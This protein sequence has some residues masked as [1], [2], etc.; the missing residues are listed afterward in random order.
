MEDSKKDFISLILCFEDE[1]DVAI[2]HEEHRQLGGSDWRES[3]YRK[4]LQYTQVTK[5]C[6]VQ[7]QL[8]YM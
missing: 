1:T 2:D 6:V 4:R 7:R 5:S 3:D 8:Y